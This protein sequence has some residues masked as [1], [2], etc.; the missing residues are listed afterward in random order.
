MARKPFTSLAGLLLILLMI[1]GSLVL[2]IGV[3]V[4]WLYLAS[5][6]TETSSPTI[7]PYI[8]VIIAIPVSM[9][10]VGRFL[11]RLNDVYG[12]VTGT[13]PEVRVRAPWLKSVRGE[14]GSGRPR[15]VLDVVMVLSVATAVLAMLI[16]FFFFAGSS[17]PTG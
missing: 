9:A 8:L 6:L 14:R 12:R 11:F 5:Q 15:T 1:V 3:P 4:G 2:W 13:T 17:L 16:W 10:I 7:G